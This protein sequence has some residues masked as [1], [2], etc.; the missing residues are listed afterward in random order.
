MPVTLSICEGGGIGTCNLFNVSCVSAT[1]E[2]LV[3]KELIKSNSIRSWHIGHDM[4]QSS[5]MGESNSFTISFTR[6]AVLLANAN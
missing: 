4:I 1:N 5:S 6:D 3:S 2:S